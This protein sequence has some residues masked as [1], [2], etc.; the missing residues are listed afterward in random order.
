[1]TVVDKL[2]P[3]YYWFKTGF[4]ETSIPLALVNFTT[5]VFV[6]LTQRGI[7][8]SLLTIPLIASGI[9]VGVVF[10]GWFMEKYDVNSRL[11]T[12]AITKQNPM[13]NEMYDDIKVIKY[14][15]DKK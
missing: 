13:L 6:A 11:A 15:L 14:K 1:M 2:I 9:M 8:I 12:H 3:L 4:G 7:E 5:I 10:I